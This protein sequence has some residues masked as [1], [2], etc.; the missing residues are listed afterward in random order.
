MKVL[1][2][3]G[4]SVGS[5]ERIKGVKKIIESQS[6]PCLIVVSA[7]QGITDDLKRLSELASIRED[8]YE[9]LLEQ[10]IGK[11]IDFSRQ[12]ITGEKLEIVI[13]DINNVASDLKETIN[14]IYL[15]RE[16]SK[17]SLDQVLAT[18]ELLSS[19]IISNFIEDSQLIDARN[20]IK[21]D[22]NYGFANVDFVKT[23][24]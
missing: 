11:H 15:L 23:Y 16:L 2:F 18:G 21:T 3:G 4:T 12:L 1:K 22:S 13:K 14:G 17:H 8:E 10:V 20:F 24:S 9:I 7:F 6:I 5:P 19:L